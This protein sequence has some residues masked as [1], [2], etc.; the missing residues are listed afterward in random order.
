M[1]SRRRIAL[2]IE[3]SNAY[4]R[5]LL[6]GIQAYARE[7][8]S[9]SSH[10]PEL[11]RGDRRLAWLSDWEGDGIIA[12]VE[13]AAIARAVAAKNLPAIDVS[14]A[15]RLPELPWVET[16]DAAIAQLAAEHLRGRGLRHFAFYGNAVFA[17]SRA[18]ERHFAAAIRDAGL[19]YHGTPRRAGLESWLLSLPRPVGLFAGYDIA[20]RELLE[21]CRAAGVRVPEQAAVLGVDNDDLLCELAVPSLT[22]IIPNTL[23]TGYEAAA[24]LDRWMSGESI[25][26]EGHFIPPLG[27]AERQSTE[28]LAVN[29]P[30]V[31]Q[32]VRFIREHAQEGITVAAVARSA[33]TSRRVL[34]HRYRKALGWS[35]HE[36]IVRSRLRFVQRLLVETE[37]PIAQIA[38]RAGFEHA[39]YLT[40]LFKRE[41]GVTPREYRAA[42]R[43]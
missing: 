37:L 2:F 11:G 29:D 18:R 33:G 40:V 35:P 24:L 22:S 3:T 34:E 25:P 1:P 4:A 16:D 39:E 32:A 30:I 9:W 5:G 19:E 10:L 41:C 31:A 26:P 14:A 36:E 6:R 28:V 43:F 21:A 13:N 27:V 8:G 17:W 15:R 23:R 7:H 12:R 42:A 20:G 38:H